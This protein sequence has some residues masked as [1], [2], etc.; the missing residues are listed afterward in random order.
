MKKLVLCCLL[1]AASYIV[2]AQSPVLNLYAYS[3]ET[4]PGIRPETDDAQQVNPLPLTYYLY[5]KVTKGQK[6]K[7]NGVW[8]KGKYFPASLEKVKSPVLVD[9]DVASINKKKLTL[10]SK[11]TQD[12]YEIK[13]K[14][15][16][17]RDFK[18]NAERDKV[19]NNEIVLVYTSNNK[20]LYSTVKTIKILPPVQ[21]M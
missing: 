18:N 12:V 4:Q 5:I 3:R 14:D 7:A 19:D 1:I 13:L 15:E 10:V 8:I 9:N 11:T 2:T 17:P 6:I 20:K 16:S 21:G